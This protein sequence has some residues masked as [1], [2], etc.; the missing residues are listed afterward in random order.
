MQNH[1]CVAETSW[2]HGSHTFCDTHIIPNHTSHQTIT[3]FL[4][5]P[6]SLST[7]HRRRSYQ[8]SHINHSYPAAFTF[9]FSPAAVIPTLSHQS[10]LS[11]RLHF[12]LFTFHFSLFTFHFSLFTFHFSLPTPTPAPHKRT[13]PTAAATTQQSASDHPQHDPPAASNAQSTAY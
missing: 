7:F 13:A 11:R 5:I 3:H 1:Q 4:P 10:L 12:S 8:L 9:H 2:G 6:F